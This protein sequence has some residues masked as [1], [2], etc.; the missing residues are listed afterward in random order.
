MTT[1]AE[2]VDQASEHVRAAI[3][4]VRG[5]LDGPA[6]YTVAGN[7]SELFG[8][9]PQLV[10]H[11]RRSVH[12]A[13]PGKHYDDRPGVPVARTFGQ[14]LDHLDTIR[15]LLDRLDEEARAAHNHLGHIGR[16]LPE[17]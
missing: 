4:V 1:V 5:P 8:R 7:L 10:D 13:D 9:L 11:L 2:H 16:H 6:A 15:A 14:A 17:D 3:H 12:R